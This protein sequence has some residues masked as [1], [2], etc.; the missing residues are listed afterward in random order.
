MQERQKQIARQLV[1]LGAVTVM[2]EAPVTFRSGLR[3]PVYVDNRSIPFHPATWHDVI[4]AFE[5]AII[6]ESVQFD[7]VAGIAAAGIPHSSAIGYAMRKPSMFIRKEAKAHGQKQ[8]IEGGDVNGKRV[9]LVEDLIT[10]GGSAIS[11]IQ[12][13]RNAGAVVEDCIAIVTYG[14]PDAI[15][16]F[17]NL[18]VRLHTL[19]SFEFILDAMRE[20]GEYNNQHLATIDR[21]L[22]A[23][24][25]WADENT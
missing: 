8:R 12:A 25:K 13:L 6:I 1:A 20:T 4:N 24:F 7:V 2:A 17:K 21:W 10:T 18:G 9:L 15:E 11:G 22:Q 14:L 23:P 3:S 19:T 16:A 5:D